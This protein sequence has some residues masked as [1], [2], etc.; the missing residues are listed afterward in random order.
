M[1]VTSSGQELQAKVLS[2]VNKLAD[3]VASTLGPKGRNVILQEKGKRPIVTKDGVSVASHFDLED[4]LENVGSQIIK[5]AAAKTNSDAGDGTTTSTVLA[6]AVVKHA[7]KYLIA[8]VSTTEMK[9]GMEK[10]LVEVKKMIVEFSNPVS[11]LEDVKSIAT[12]SAN[13]DKQIGTLISMAVDKAGRDGAVTIE[14]ARSTE[15]SLDVVEGFQFDSGWVSPRF[16]NDERKASFRYTDTLVL[17]TDHSVE[18]MED[19]LPALEIAAREKRPLVIVADDVSGPAL[20]GLIMNTVRGNMKVAAV[21]APRYGEERRQILSDLATSVGAT[22]ITREMG[23]LLTDAKRANLGFA[24]MFESAK[25]VTTVMGGNG[26]PSKIRDRIDALKEEIG[27]TPDLR[28]CERIQ[29]R[30]SRLQ[31]AVAIVRVGGATEVDMIE[32]KDRVI[33]ALEAV[34]SAQAEG[35]LPGG[36]VSLVHF[37]VLLEKEL[38]NDKSLTDD[39]RIGQKILVEAMREPFKTIAENCGLNAEYLLENQKRSKWRKGVNFVNGET[40]DMIETG[41]IDPAKVTRCALENAV[42]AASTLLTT[43]HAVIEV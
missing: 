41:I 39:E 2:G 31:S 36:G 40:V 38:R 1:K 14:E 7:Q 21:K 5:Q 24:K 23:M 16:I 33:D 28:D 12:I 20:A 42:S 29:E 17:V 32:R 6:R 35:I 13:N 19:L 9:R 25:S 26:D 4:P 22:F 27:R 18:N 11:S 8:G 3:A 43:S 37:S 34:K 10:A 30:I 15:T